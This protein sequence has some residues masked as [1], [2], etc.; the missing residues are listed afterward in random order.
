MI[1]TRLKIALLIVVGIFSFQNN[2]FA[3]KEKIDSDVQLAMRMIGHE[4]LLSAGDSSS[5]VLPI[6]KDG[7]RYEI[8]FEVELEF[9]PELLIYLVSENL[10][11]LPNITSY[12]TEVASCVNEEIVYTYKVG[13]TKE[14]NILPCGGRNLP[15]GCYK[16]YIT[17]LKDY[18]T[19]FVA[20]HYYP[21]TSN[22]V[23][24]KSENRTFLISLGIITPLL[25]IGFLIFNKKERKPIADETATEIEINPNLI[26]VGKYQ[27]DKGTLK[28]SIDDKSVELSG[29]EADLLIVLHQNTNTTVEREQLLKEVWGDEG[30]YVGRTLDVFISKLRKRLKADDNIKIVNVRGVGYRFVVEVNG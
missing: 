23:E 5:R 2:S 17:F 8:S 3:E 27:F 21:V 6:Q 11:K 29:K 18:T 16:V 20:S 24:Q 19:D 10:K 4:L 30:D 7:N 22:K 9:S 28:L 26:S 14:S 12:L 13:N 1:N 25:L 15:K